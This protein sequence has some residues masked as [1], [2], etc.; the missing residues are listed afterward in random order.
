MP[1]ETKAD[2]SRKYSLSDFQ[3]IKVLGK[4]SFGKVMLAEKKGSDEI[5]A[6]KVRQWNSER[7]LR[8]L[9]KKNVLNY[10]IDN[11][12]LILRDFHFQHCFLFHCFYIFNFSV[13][14]A[15]TK[16]LEGRTFLED[17]F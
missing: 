12:S 2:G 1:V 17:D 14:Y 4:G 13:T 10:K 3:F 9:K 11:Y 7:L 16:S 15:L 6:V 8:R 5:F